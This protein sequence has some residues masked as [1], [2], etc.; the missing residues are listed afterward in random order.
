MLDT[1]RVLLSSHS[2]GNAL[3]DSMLTVHDR[4]LKAVPHRV[5]APLEA[6]PR[7]TFTS[8]LTPEQLFFSKLSLKQRLATAPSM[9]KLMRQMKRS[10]A[11][12]EHP[13]LS[14]E[15]RAGSSGG[16][17][18]CPFE[19]RFRTCDALKGKSGVAEAR[20]AGR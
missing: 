4:K 18:T 10:A 7:R 19:P 17:I 3:L 14:P 9:V 6:P 2:G 5:E 13:L 12:Y 1:L 16:R 20:E 11:Y 8:T 15:T